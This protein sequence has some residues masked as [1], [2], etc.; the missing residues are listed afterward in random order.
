MSTGTTE[1]WWT[2]ESNEPAIDVCWLVEYGYT[3][4]DP[5][6][7]WTPGADAEVEIIKVTTQEGTEVTLTKEQESDVADYVMSEILDACEYD[8]PEPRSCPRWRDINDD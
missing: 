1:Y 8:P 3:P 7:A 5:G 2:D 4:A 6:D